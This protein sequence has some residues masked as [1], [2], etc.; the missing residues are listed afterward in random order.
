LSTRK[1]TTITATAT[2]T[3]AKAG[4]YTTFALGKEEFGIE[5]FKSPRNYR[6][7]GHHGSAIK[8][9]LDIDHILEG[10]GTRM[11]G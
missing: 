3:R 7:H 11:A 5:I 4:K 1:Y 2:Q 8:L 9:M 10:E 6:S